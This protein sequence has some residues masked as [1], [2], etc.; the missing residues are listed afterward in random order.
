VNFDGWRRAE[1]LEALLFGGVTLLA[2]KVIE[3]LE[4]AFEQFRKHGV[5]NDDSLSLLNRIFH[6]LA[7]VQPPARGIAKIRELSEEFHLY[8]HH[9]RELLMALAQC[10]CEEG[11]A[12]LKDLAT[13]SGG[14]FQNIAREWFDAVAASHLPEAEALLLAFVDPNVNGALRVQELPNYMDDHLAALLAN[15]ANTDSAIAARL[16][17]LTDQPLSPRQRDILTKIAVQLDSPQSLLTALNLLDDESQ[18]PVPFHLWRALEDLFLEKRPYKESSGSYSLVPRAANDIRKRLFEI[19][20]NDP[21]RSRAA[22]NLLGQIEEWRLRY[23]R[24]SSELRHPAY[25]SGIPWPPP[26]AAN[27]HE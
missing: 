10:E 16:L 26:I 27:V 23:G 15:V 6:L 9:H 17:Q 24:P 22:Y 3:T 25:E 5:Y 12:F 14:G 8:L 18:Q 21:R 13:Q 11:I 1:I 2:D 19:A 7:F 20:E 4:P